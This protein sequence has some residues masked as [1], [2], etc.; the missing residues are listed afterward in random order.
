MSL[1]DKGCILLEYFVC[2]L[3]QVITIPCICYR[4]GFW[5]SLAHLRLP[6][7]TPF[8]SSQPPWSLNSPRVN[9]KSSAICLHIVSQQ[10][11]FS[12]TPNPTSHNFLVNFRKVIYPNT[13]PQLFPTHLYNYIYIF[14]LFNPEAPLPP[15]CYN[16]WCTFNSTCIF[17]REEKSTW[18]IVRA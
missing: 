12:P 1:R 18:P 2:S 10:P 7:C 3:I 11:P 14:L 5:I 8:F 17:L 13:I 16:I 15:P 4:C 9:T 6:S